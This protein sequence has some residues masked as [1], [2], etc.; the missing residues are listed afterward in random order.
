MCFAKRLGRLLCCVEGVFIVCGMALGA[1]IHVSPKGSDEAPGSVREP[2]LTLEK[3]RL[4]AREARARQPGE[5]V[6][7]LLHPGT[8]RVTRTVAFT[9]EDAGTR[10][11]PLQ[12]LAW[13]TPST[14]PEARPVLVG[15][16]VVTGWKACSFNGRDGVFEAD[17]KPLGITTPFRQVYLNGQRLIWARYPNADPALPYSGGWAYVDGVRPPMYKDIEGE[18]TD[19]VVLRERDVHAWSRPEEGEMCIFPRYNWWNRIEKIAAFDPGSRTF[20]LAKKMPYAARPED[21]YCVMGLREELDAPG[22]WFQDV[23]GQRLYLI[24][25]AGADLTRDQITVPTVNDILSFN[26]THHVR[27]ANLELTC[28]ETHAL[29]FQDCDHMTVE[30]CRIHDLGFFSGS[31]IGIRGGR[32]GR[33]RGC[34]IWHI[35]GHGVSVYAGDVD[36]MTRCF[37]EVENCYIHHV[38]Q[39]NRHGLGVMIGGAGVRVAHN[40]MHDL[41]RSG[42]FHGGVLHTLEYNRIRHCNLEMEDTGCTYT[43]GWCGGWHTIRY[44][45]CSDSIGFNNHG[46]FF[47][48]AWGIYLDESGCGNDVYGNLVERCQVGAMHLHNAREN[49]IYNNIFANNAGPEGKTHQFSLQTWNNSPTAVFLRDRQPK[50]LKAYTRLMA[51]PEWAKMRGMHVSPADPFLPDGTIMR[52]NRI[53][54]NIFLY[55]EQPDSRYIRENGVNLTH[56]LINSNVVWNGGAQPVKTGKQAVRRPIADLTERI[57]NAA[58]ARAVDAAALASDP[59]Q[60][61]AAEWFWYQKILPGLQ[62]ERV[63]RGDARALRLFGAF[64]GERK[65]IKYPCVRSAP[66]TLP[67]GKH[68]RLTFALRH[69]EAD[70]EVLVRLVCENKGLWK[71][72]GPRGFL[73]R[74]D[75]SDISTASEALPCETGFYLPKPGEAG[76]DAR[77]EAFTLHFEFQSKQ[78][79]AEISGLRLEEVEPASEWEAWQM[80]GADRDSVVADPQFVDA[81]RGD[82]RL[83]PDSPAL[84]LGFEPIAFDKIGPYPDAARATWPIIEAEGVR[85]HPEWL[86]SVPIPK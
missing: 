56:N 36:S 48:F 77:M 27:I 53:F 66:F 49:H 81:A 83:K 80:A 4:L 25:P 8:H 13:R 82:F 71:A 11:A 65:Y 21:R 12:L 38:G 2:V 39:F 54:R 79:W 24:P 75:M 15:G 55:S 58:F 23:A 45:H 5:P 26:K 69:H 70:G 28:A 7:L 62:A 50:M 85:E 40:L 31:G 30:A 33:I 59:N 29:R 37:H 72:L 35:G 68:Y 76:F 78:G 32:E 60:T 16:K 41:P 61:I 44:N 57:P 52:G 20:T 14:P 9:A 43:G 84:K 19:T 42:I 1:E 18:R 34:D 86:T 51:N 67:Y 10:E 17:L 6:S 63:T 3:A 47:V 73:K 74:S 22:E 46:K 64:N